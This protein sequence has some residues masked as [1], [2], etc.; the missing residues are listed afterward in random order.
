MHM[1]VRE[2]QDWVERPSLNVGGTITRAG[3]PGV[4]ERWE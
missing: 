2:F 4:S 1:S 3:G